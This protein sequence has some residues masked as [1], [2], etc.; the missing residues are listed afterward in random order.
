MFLQLFYSVINRFEFQYGKHIAKEKLN[1]ILKIYLVSKNCFC[2][3]IR[4]GTI[5]EKV[6]EQFN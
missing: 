1:L 3:R 2:I 4:V 5:K 6:I